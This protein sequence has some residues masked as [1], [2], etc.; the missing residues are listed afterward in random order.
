MTSRAIVL[1]AL[2]ILLAG[3]AAHAQEDA[4]VELWERPYSLSIQ[5][6]SFFI[7]EAFN[8]EDRVMQHITTMTQFSSPLRERG[9]SF[10]QEWP[11]GGVRHQLS[12]EL[13]YADAG[14]ETGIADIVLNYRYQL[15]DKPDGVAFSPRLSVILPT[16]D[17]DRGLGMGV[18]GLEVNLPVSKRLSELFVGHANAGVALFPSVKGATLAGAEV[19][20]TVHAYT[21]GASAIALVHPN[22]N[23]MLE[24]LAEF[25]SELAP[26]GDLATSTTQILSPGLRGAINMGSLQIVPGLAVP[27]RFHEAGS[28]T[29]IFGY[30]SFEHGF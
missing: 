24:Y 19:H 14:G 1:A 3:V 25:G 10:T 27:V 8:Q 13:G 22:L 11:V 9:H 12:Y 21:L 20:R 23:L 16:G 15:L 17:A 4:P 5:D 6:N 30:V 18:A 2:S 26:T 28:E 7:E 29:G